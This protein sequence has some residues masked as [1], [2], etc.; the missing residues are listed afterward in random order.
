MSMRARTCPTHRTAMHRLI[1]RSASGHEL[2]LD[3]CG[4]C[5]A[6]WFDAGELEQLDRFRARPAG[7]GFERVCPSCSDPEKDPA[8]GGA[9]T[10]A[11]CTS[12]QGTF[13]DAATVAKLAS[14]RLP[15]LPEAKRSAAELG[16]RCA[17]CE[18]RFPYSE[19]TAVAR[20]LVCKGC[21]KQA[22]GVAKKPELRGVFDAVFDFLT[23]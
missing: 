10:A 17:E 5:G 8:V 14:D 23:E 9:F 7:P 15:R 6:L 22:V 19:S 1:A 13:L 2:E 18:Q 12:C 20:G 16:F 3:R 11:Q 21:A 4:D